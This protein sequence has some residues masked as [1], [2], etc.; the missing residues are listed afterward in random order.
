MAKKRLNYREQKFI[1][2]KTKGFNNRDSALYAGYSPTSASVTA[3]R[4]MKKEQIL[5]VL[6]KVG[7][8]DEALAQT[9][10]ENIEAGTG[11]KATADTALK[12]VELA[13]KLKGHL[14]EEKTKDLT[15]TNI[16]INE[17]KSLDDDSLS[18]KLLELSKGIIV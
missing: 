14:T 7:L 5:H 3:N 4:L 18:N 12:G 17:L 11:I 9:I 13:L 2:A 15:Q 6:D 1:E 8:T 16:Y 10:K